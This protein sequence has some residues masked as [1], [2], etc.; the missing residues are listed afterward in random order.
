MDLI[1]FPESLLSYL[2]LTQETRQKQAG[3]PHRGRLAEEP[4][5]T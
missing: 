4:I 5:P 3:V 1:P 2:P